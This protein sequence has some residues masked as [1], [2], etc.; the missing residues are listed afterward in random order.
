MSWHYLQGGEAA[1][2]VDAY[3]AGVR[4]ARWRLSD[5]PEKS[6]SPDSETACCR[7]SRSG[8]MCGHLT[9]APGAALSMSSAEGSRARISAAQDEEQ[10]LTASAADFG[11]RCG[12]LLARFD[13]G[14]RSWRIPLYLFPEDSVEFSGTWPKSGILLRGCAYPLKIVVP[15]T[16]EKES[17]F[18]RWMTPQASDAL[19][20]KLSEAAL[21][22]H[23]YKRGRLDGLATQVHLPERKALFPTPK[24]SDCKRN[25]G[26]AEQA[27]ESVDLPAFVALQSGKRVGGYLNPP[28]VEWLMGWP[29]GWTDLRPL[30]TGRFLSWR[31]AHFARCS[32]NLNN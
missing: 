8:T 30:G 23:Y 7:R 21:L 6:C 25:G 16:R 28:W 18:L 17:G 11:P 19:R 27:R 22:K 10:V 13:R 2:S 24:A 3:L 4:S 31:R 32:E 29:Q 26:P 14:S 9:D 5:T 20:T 15:R 1:F 12:E